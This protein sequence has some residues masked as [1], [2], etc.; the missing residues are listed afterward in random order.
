MRLILIRHGESLIQNRDI[1]AGVRSCQGL[2]DRGVRQAQM[3][4]ERFRIS[5]EIRD[6]AALLS[7]PVLRARQTAEELIRS[8]PARDIE[9]HSELT[10]IDVGVADGITR[11]E[12]RAKHGEFN[13]IE[14]PDR[15]F[16][17][18]GE[19]WG[20]YLNRVRLEMDRLAKRFSGQT[21]V[22]VTHA[23]FIVV[24]ILTTFGIPRPGTCAR[25]E[26]DNT[27]LTEW[28]F[29]QGTWQLQRYNDTHHLRNRE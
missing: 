12:Y 4:A 22:A 11:A 18:G 17:P 26:P 15:P 27:S 29:D 7:S 5:G 2:T 19:S 8:L 28:R 6:C 1:I 21:V 14:H 3:L 23:G 16:A 10:E 9:E 25:L 24:S 13:L 20:Q